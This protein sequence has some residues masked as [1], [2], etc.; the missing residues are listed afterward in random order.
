LTDGTV[1]LDGAGNETKRIS[2]ADIMGISMGRRAGLVFALISG[3]GG[4]VL[5]AI[6]AKVGVTEIYPGCKDKAQALRDFAAKHEIAVEEV[7][8]VGDDVND[9]GALRLGGLAVAPAGAHA[10][11]T[12]AAT[13]VTAARGGEGCVREVVDM[14]LAKGSS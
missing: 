13:M 5:D 9:V 6:A 10:S 2:F 8:F 12:A 1:S 3:E 11:A 14:L 4:P 7:C